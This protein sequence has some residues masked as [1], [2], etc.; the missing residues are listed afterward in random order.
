MDEPTLCLLEVAGTWVSGI[1]ALLAVGVSLHLARQQTAVKL[2]VRAGPRVIVRPGEPEMPEYIS[3][4]VVN[5][6]Q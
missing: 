2:A 1:G 5:L 3:V 4:H 6:G